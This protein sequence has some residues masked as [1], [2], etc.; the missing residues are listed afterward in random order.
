DMLDDIRERSLPEVERDI[1]EA[2]HG[3]DYHLTFVDGIPE[4]PQ[5]AR[6]TR[7]SLLQFIEDRFPRR[8]D[9][10]APHVTGD[11]PDEAE[12]QSLSRG[13]KYTAKM[14]V[15]AARYAM[16]QKNNLCKADG[17]PNCDAIAR[18]WRQHLN[19]ND[20]RRGLSEDNIARRLSEGIDAI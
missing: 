9:P 12:L 4:D 7:P 10:A 20:H 13:E 17:S 5:Q 14:L 18:L 8:N 6:V 19:S 15:L 1:D 11:I 3:R 16:T 2:H